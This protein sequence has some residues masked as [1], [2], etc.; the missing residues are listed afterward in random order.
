MCK[1]TVPRSRKHNFSLETVSTKR[2]CWKHK[3]HKLRIFFTLTR[4]ILPPLLGP[5]TYPFAHSSQQ[6]S[7]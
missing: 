1:S 2:C 6:T 3:A 4:I 7:T 5:I